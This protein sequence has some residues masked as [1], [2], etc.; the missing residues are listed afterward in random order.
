MRILQEVR[1]DFDDVLFVPKRSTLS[2]RKDVQ[3]LRMY[4][5]K[6]TLQ[7]SYWGIP[8][9]AANMDTVA[10]IPTAIA[11][12][13]FDM[14]TCLHKFVPFKDIVDAVKDES[15]N[16]ENFAITIGMNK[17]VLVE[18]I[19]IE[20]YFDFLCIDVANGYTETFSEFVKV[21][22]ELFPGKILIAGNVCTGDMTSE[23]IL[24]G[25][26]I[27]KVGIGPGSM[28]KT[29]LKA[30][31]GMPQL[32]AIIECADAAHGMGGRI[33]ADGGCKY[34][35]DI[36]KA[37]GAG[38]DFVMVGS[39]FAAHD[40][41]SEFDEEG[42]A[43][44]YGMSSNAAMKKHYGGTS[45]YKTSEGRVARIKGRGPISNTVQDILGSLRSTCAYV[46]AESLKDLSKCTTFV[47]VNN[48]LSTLH[49]SNTI[50]E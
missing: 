13:K 14:F 28:C 29:R 20:E 37:I 10:N 47:M 41:N 16:V 30:G 48:Q 27:V 39:M 2:S 36:A 42:Y 3:L 9:M 26:D 5:F 44:V 21:V 6:H 24:A 31:V 35:A 34:P 23:L 49:E 15:L 32:S 40:E 46:G 1:L 12:Q 4:K 11:L 38:A 19:A 7:P 50:G 25:A 43:Q 17:D 8:I 33:I 22:R 45:A 18:L